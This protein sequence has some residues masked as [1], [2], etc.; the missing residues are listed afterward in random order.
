MVRHHAFSTGCQSYSQFTSSLQLEAEASP[1]PLHMA[2]ALRDL[3]ALRSDFMARPTSGLGVSMDSFGLGA[4]SPVEELNAL[5]GAGSIIGSGA[6]TSR[7]RS[8][9]GRRSASDSTLLRYARVTSEEMTRAVRDN[10]GVDVTRT[11]LR[12]MR[13]SSFVASL[14]INRVSGDASDP[15]SATAQAAK[16]L[17]G[18][19][20]RRNST[21]N[22]LMSAGRLS[23]G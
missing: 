10:L 3:E 21:E 4:T 11:S 22:S 12:R 5:S 18:K 23:L 13:A 17:G 19:R 8:S 1:A 2:V 16:R 6:S 7:T 20:R 15:M 14:D 9:M